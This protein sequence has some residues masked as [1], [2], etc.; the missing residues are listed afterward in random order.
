MEILKASSGITVLF[1]RVPSKLINCAYFVKCGSVDEV[2]TEQEGLC[3]ALEHMLFQGTGSRTWQQIS[4]DFRRFGS[5]FNAHTDFDVTSYEIKCPKEFFEESFEVLADQIYNSTMPS[6]RWEIERA[7]IISEIQ[8]FLDTPDRLLGFLGPRDAFGPNYKDPI[9]NIENLNNATVRDLK[10]FKDMFYKGRNIFISIT[11]DLTSKQVLRVIDLYDRWEV[12]NCAV[13][14]KMD[15]SFNPNN[16]VAK[17][18]GIEQSYI[19]FLSPMRKYRR[20]KEQIAL[21]IGID[22]LYNYLYENIVWRLGLCYGIRPYHFDSIEGCE[23]LEIEVACSAEKVNQLVEEVPKHLD[24]FLRNELSKDRIE[25]ARRSKLRETI[26]RQEDPAAVVAWM[27]ES[28]LDGRTK[29]PF[30]ETFHSIVRVKDNTVRSI[31]TEFLTV[32]RKLSV[33]TGDMEKYNG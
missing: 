12:K 28:Y 31:M 21:D 1:K 18:A 26:E 11:G 24:S 10:Y 16:F 29:D 22:L 8:D 6:E 13:R 2:L 4:Q 33:L 14:K 27:A 17:K 23:F 25:D 7:T 32:D 15:F 5:Y 20:I 9:G 30:D 3:H 19:T